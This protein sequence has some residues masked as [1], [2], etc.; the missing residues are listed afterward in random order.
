MTDKKEKRK[1]SIPVIIACIV[2]LAQGLFVFYLGIESLDRSG[3]WTAYLFLSG[4]VELGCMIGF[5]MMKRWIFFAYLTFIAIDQ[6]FGISIGQWHIITLLI[7]AVVI[8]LTLCSFK[9]M[10]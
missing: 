9:K 5:L 4:V 7:P 6:I 3:D 1:P 2:L 8:L 10:R